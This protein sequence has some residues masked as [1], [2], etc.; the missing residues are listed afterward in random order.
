[1]IPYKQLSLADIFENCQKDFENDKYRFLALLENAINL[2]EIVPQSFI[3]H[4]RARTG[5]PRK[6]RLF[7]ILWALILQRIFSIPTDTLLIIFLKYSKE[8]HDF[9]GFD[10]V[11]DTSKI[12]C[13]KQDFLPDLQ[14]MCGY[15]RTD[16]PT[17]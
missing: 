6:Y 17:N 10:K 5:R 2:E 16:M 13:F 12:T 1:M 11:P 9:C 15:D 8:L 4:F 7:A 14:S 3:N